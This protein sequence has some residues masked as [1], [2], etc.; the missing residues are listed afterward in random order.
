VLSDTSCSWG[1]S[2]PTIAGRAVLRAR[3]DDGLEAQRVALGQPVDVVLLDLGL[4]GARGL[5][6]LRVIRA[7]K[8]DLPVLIVT[9]ASLVE[10]RVEGLDAGADDYLSKPVVFAELLAR[11]RAVLRRGNRGGRA[12]PQIE[13]LELDR[14]AHVS[15]VCEPGHRAKS[16]GICAAGTVDVQRG[17]ARGADSVYRACLEAASI[18]HDQR[19]GC[20]HQL[21]TR[22]GL[23]DDGWEC[24]A[25]LGGV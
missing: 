15:A 12:V 6:V 25:R 21:S 22:G 9:G 2:L 5:E 10:K 1:I 20:L 16:K 18:H 4:P 8:P 23:P 17:T 13:D 11:I 14:K 3:G 24:E 7:T 19:R